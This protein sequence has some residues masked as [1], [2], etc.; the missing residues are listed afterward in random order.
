MPG[1]SDR[2]QHDD[3][4]LHIAEGPADVLDSFTAHHLKAAVTVM[5]TVGRTGIS[6]ALI[7]IPLKSCWTRWKVTLVL[8]SEEILTHLEEELARA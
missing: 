8:K 7:A 3:A 1:F 5:G 4:H 2:I 6:G